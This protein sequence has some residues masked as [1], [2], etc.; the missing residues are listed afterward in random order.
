[1]TPYNI[2]KIKEGIKRSI[3][4]G[5]L[6][7]HVY[8]YCSI[9]R[10]KER[11][12]N[13]SLYFCSHTDFNDPLDCH[14]DFH[15]D[16]TIQELALHVNH[17][18]APHL[19]REMVNGIVS[20]SL[21]SDDVRKVHFSDNCQEVIKNMGICC[22]SQN[23]DHILLWSHYGENHK[24]VCL[25]F[26]ITK[27][28]D[29]FVIPSAVKYQEAFPKV[30][31]IKNPFDITVPLLTKSKV[32]EYENEVRVCKRAGNKGDHQFKVSALDEVIFG[33]NADKE[34]IQEIRD[35]VQER[36]YPDVT[37]KQAKIRKGHYALDILPL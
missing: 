29:F 14:V 28:L 30:N 37:F 34:F 10:A 17:Y 21:M 35:I 6:P 27:D 1:M 16:S 3:N 13:S 32:W 31:I 33:C 4:N 36:T 15:T 19:P 23:C 8:K 26:D 5:S 7:Q 11:L 20:G 12:L 22:F 2:D 18:L 24:G 9:L 25:R